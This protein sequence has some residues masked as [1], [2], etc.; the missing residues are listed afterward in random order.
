[1]RTLAGIALAALVA[2]PGRAGQLAALV[3]AYDRLALGECRK[4]AE[5]VTLRSGGLSTTWSDGTVC[6]VNAGETA[7]G[8]YFSGR[9]VFT[10]VSAD[11]V[12]GPVYAFNVKRA[13]ALEVTPRTDGTSLVARFRTALWLAAGAPNPAV[14]LGGPVETPSDFARHRET[15]AAEYEAVPSHIFPAQRLDRG[16]GPVVR[17]EMSGGDGDFVHVRDEM[18]RRQESL[19]VVKAIA[20]QDPILKRRREIVVLSGLPVGRN[21]REPLPPSFV[22]RAV[23]YELT[24][25]T[26]KDAVLRVRE[27]IVPVRDGL[28]VLRFDLWNELLVD[29]GPGTLGARRMQVRGVTDGGGRNLEFDHRNDEVVVALPAAAAAAQPITLQ[30]ELAGDVL[31]RP[32]G[33]NYWLLEGDRLFPQPDTEGSAYTVHATIRARKPFV[34]FGPG[35]IVARSASDEHNVVETRSDIPVRVPF[36]LAGRYEIFEEM[37][38]GLTVRVACYAGRNEMAEKQLATL[39]FDAVKFFE[40]F[41]GPFPF[42]ELNIVQIHQLGWGQAPPATMFITSEAFDRLL[43]EAVAA[44]Y[45]QGVNER[46]AHEI[47]H[48]YWGQSVSWPSAEETWLSES[49]AEY[50]AGLLLRKARGEDDYKKI[51]SSWKGFAKEATKAAPIPLASR[52]AVP[53]DNALEFRLRVG[54]LYN[55]GPYLLS[56][57]HAEV[58]EE[59]FLTFLK[60]FQKSFRGK[61]GS[62][63]HVVGVLKFVTGRDYAPFFE[64]NFWGTGLPN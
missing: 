39:A 40:R 44:V 29:R 52:I 26:E 16:A 62:T 4:L 54:L 3:E 51:V 30:F 50:C 24:Q 64:A 13:T 60:S 1:V 63:H 36:A 32:G 34:P 38:D 35:E 15:F 56:R 46:F 41:L 20:T 59:K 2:A 57:I 12:E 33:D 18:W 55:K 58:G 19:R 11:P 7:V 49:F 61:S 17:V 45:T 27:T 10:H 28:R 25:T 21:R 48:Q 5:P 31:I 47:A 23:D 42:R 53:G 8:W 9:G 14:P 22:V 37:R 6:A 43:P